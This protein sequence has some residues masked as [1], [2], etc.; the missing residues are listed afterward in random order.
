M[1]L[2]LS[3]FGR[4]EQVRGSETGDESSE[5]GVENGVLEA[6]TATSGRGEP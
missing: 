6:G 1:E 4:D 5:D 3:Q 2:S